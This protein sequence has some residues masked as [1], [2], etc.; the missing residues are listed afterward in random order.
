[1]AFSLERFA[2]L[3]PYLYHLTAS[4]N[5]PLIRESK[6]LRCAKDILIESSYHEFVRTKRNEAVLANSHEQVIHVRDQSPLH[7]GN[8]S[9]EDGWTFSDLVEDLNSRVYFWPG[10]DSGPIE[11]GM[12]HFKRYQAERPT[13]LR[14]NTLETFAA[15]D[16]EPTFCKF[17]SGSPR[18]SR[19][20]RSPRGRSTFV[21]HSDASFRATKVVEVSFISTMILPLDAEVSDLPTGRWT[22]LN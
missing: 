18:C 16:V 5:V 6:I 14:L 17:N 11:H 7:S 2:S 20:K 13:I 22:K 12:R 1:M 15:N 8:I 4:Q 19:G 3:R 9:F 10:K 21:N